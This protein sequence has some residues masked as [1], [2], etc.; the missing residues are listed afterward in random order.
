MVQPIVARRDDGLVIG[1]H[2]RLVAAHRL[3]MATVPVVWV[4]LPVTRSRL[5]A[6]A[7]NKISGEWDE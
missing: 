1:G 5:L 3:G 6:L 7:L 4:D 2:Q